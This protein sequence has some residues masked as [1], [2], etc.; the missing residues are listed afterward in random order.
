MKNIKNF[1][2]YN[3]GR[4]VGFK[5]TEPKDMY[6]FDIH[7]DVSFEKVKLEFIPLITKLIEDKDIPDFK[8]DIN[9]NIISCEFKS[10]HDREAVFMSQEVIKEI[11]RVIKIDPVLITMNGGKLYTAPPKPNILSNISPD[12]SKQ[13]TTNRIEK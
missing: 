2:K 12:T 5:Y 4:K 10:Y 3:E 1:K 6:I 7:Y 8:L 11:E 13:Q 9:N